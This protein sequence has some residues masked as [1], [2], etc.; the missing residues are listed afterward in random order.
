[1]HSASNYI[2]IERF[3]M[4][5]TTKP[6]GDQ[7]E[8]KK[9]W[10]MW[11]CPVCGHRMFIQRQRTTQNEKTGQTYIET[12]HVCPVDDY[13]LT[14]KIPRKLAET[15]VDEKYLIQPGNDQQFPLHI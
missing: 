3:K 2:N 8:E 9:Q 6:T 12:T 4:E 13:W 11:N 7:P 14:T 1:M 5:E 10:P 15:M